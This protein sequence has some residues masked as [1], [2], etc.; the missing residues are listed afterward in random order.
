MTLRQD[1]NMGL[2]LCSSCQEL[3]HASSCLPASGSRLL[4]EMHRNVT[5]AQAVYSTLHCCT[6]LVLQTSAAATCTESCVGI[7]LMGAEAP[8]LTH[9]MYRLCAT[10]LTWPSVTDNIVQKSYISY[11][12]EPRGSYEAAMQLDLQWF[13]SIASSSD[14]SNS[15]A[16]F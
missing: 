14:S 4:Y 5:Y 16:I 8:G 6:V 7:W 12:P 3:E 13:C 9:N 11:W 1:S 10:C 2:L 15:N